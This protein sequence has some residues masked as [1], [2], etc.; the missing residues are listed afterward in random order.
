VSNQ[1]TALIDLDAMLHIVA[2]VQL[3]AGNRN[4]PEMVKNH[5]KRFISNI[6]QSSTCTHSIYFYQDSG[7]VNF[8]N[9]ILPDYKSHRTTSEAIEVWKPTILEAFKEV[10]AIPLRFIESD[11][12]ISL[13]AEDIGYDRVVI[14]SSD[15][16]MKQIPSLHYNPFKP[17][18]VDDPTR[19]VNVNMYQAERFFWEQVLSGDATD[20][21][22]DKCGIQG[23]GPAK[24]ADMCDNEL[25]YNQIIKKEYSKKYGEKE[26]YKRANTT[27]M[28]IRLLR[29]ANS[30]Y[31]NADA[32]EEVRHLL[33]WYH[34]NVRPISNAVEA[35]FDNPKKTP[36]SLFN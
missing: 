11:D 1:K 15:K 13:I 21:P 23:I 32:Q 25:T 18:K 12:A 22:N 6:E 26:G 29:V 7:H 28:M 3:K 8:R 10:T 27:Y 30:H 31:I 14:I 20:M 17:G 2:N 33:E 5:I 19:W 36:P 9:T 35:L 4:N 34:L 24:A 16:D